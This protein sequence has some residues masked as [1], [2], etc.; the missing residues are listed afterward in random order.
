MSVG[1]LAQAVAGAQVMGGLPPMPGHAECTPDAE[2]AEHYSSAMFTTFGKEL[3]SMYTL[4]ADNGMHDPGVRLKLYRN[5][6]F[7][8]AAGRCRG[9]PTQQLHITCQTEN[10][11][12][13]KSSQITSEGTL[14]SSCGR[15]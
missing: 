15:N 2:S 11:P 3:L 8:S 12:E 4:D 5:E 7:M 9:G 13:A 10:S 1:V 14:D 6:M